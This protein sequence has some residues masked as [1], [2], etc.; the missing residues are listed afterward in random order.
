[1]IKIYIDKP[2]LNMAHR[3]ETEHLTY[4]MED[5][6]FQPVDALEEADCVLLEQTQAN[7]LLERVRAFKPIA[8]KH[9]VDA[10]I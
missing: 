7:T 9:S 10:F 6:N 2:L 4:L 8:H 3:D 1:M 5:T